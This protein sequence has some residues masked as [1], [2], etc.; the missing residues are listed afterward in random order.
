MSNDKLPYQ[1][2]IKSFFSF[3]NNI[4][5]LYEDI[6]SVISGK[7]GT[8]IKKE[9]SWNISNFNKANSD[10]I[11][12]YHFLYN[13]LVYGISILASIDLEQKK[14]SDYQHFITE[15]D[16]NP[17]IPLIVVCGVFDP[18][19]KE[20]YN[21]TEWWRLCL[22]YEKWGEVIYPE[23]IKYNQPIKLPTSI[24][25]GS[26]YWFKNSTFFI[27]KLLNI[28]EQNNITELVERLLNLELE[29]SEQIVQPDP[30][31]RAFS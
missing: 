20:Q 6:Q 18:I 29:T 31:A 5:S 14:T 24:D 8:D 13:D 9:N 27:T 30:R 7:L 19:D 17:Q 26:Y 28:K 2:T 12:Q 10:Y 1:N 25:S 11:L 16:F 21:A 15:L 22:G 3:K 23:K 4:V